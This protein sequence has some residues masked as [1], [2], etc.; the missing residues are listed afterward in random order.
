MKRRRADRKVERDLE[1]AVAAADRADE[2][3]AAA[4]DFAIY[5]VASAE[6]AVLDAVDLRLAAEAMPSP[7]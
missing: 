3:A 2:D 1:R 5:A 6:Y 4:V 7:A